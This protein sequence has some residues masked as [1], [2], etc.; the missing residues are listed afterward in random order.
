MDDVDR[1]SPDE[2][3]TKEDRLPVR[4]IGDRSDVNA[5]ADIA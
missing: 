2:T 4:L 1:I 3:R 5:T